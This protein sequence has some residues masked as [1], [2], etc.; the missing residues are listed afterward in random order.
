M[1]CFPTQATN[2]D[3]SEKKIKLIKNLWFYTVKYKFI[4]S[5]DFLTGMEMK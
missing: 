1:S 3:F 5:L 2:K 4:T